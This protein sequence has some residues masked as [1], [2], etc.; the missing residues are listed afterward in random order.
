[1]LL[2][3]LRPRGLDFFDE[4]LPMPEDWP[5]A[6]CAFV[7]LSRS[8]DSNADTAVRRGWDSYRLDLHHFA[9]LT[10]VETV[11][12]TLHRAIGNL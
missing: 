9:A 4:E 2:A 11:A 12:E 10:D 3:G 6:R 5:D 1:M 7:R 8:Y